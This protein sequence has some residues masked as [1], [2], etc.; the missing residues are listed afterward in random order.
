MIRGRRV[1][2]VPAGRKPELDAFRTT[3]DDDARD[4]FFTIYIFFSR[5]R[6]THS[7]LLSIRKAG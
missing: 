6:E 5:T 3:L 7:R 2:G 1:R 4:F